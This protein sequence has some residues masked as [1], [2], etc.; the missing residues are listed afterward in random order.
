[1]QMKQMRRS[2]PNRI[3]RSILPMLLTILAMSVQAQDQT[4]PLLAAYQKEFV[5]LD[6]EI[7]LLR[8]RIEEVKSDGEIR[9]AKAGADL[10]ELEAELLAVTAKVDRRSEDL[11][12]VE[13]EGSSADDATDTLYAILT[14]AA[15]RLDNFGI[16]PF[17]PQQLSQ[18]IPEQDKM[19]MELEYGF[20][21]SFAL[22]ETLSSF[23]TVEDTF[24]LVDG[25]QVA[26]EIVHLG[27]IA[28]Y[29]IHD[30][31]SGTLAPAGGGRLKMV[32]TDSGDVARALAD[33]KTPA[34]LP[35]YLYESLDASAQTESEKSL[36]DTIEGGGM[37]GLVILGIGAV[38]LLLILLRILTLAVVSR[39]DSKALGR[40]AEQVSG[41]SLEEA[42]ETSGTLP[43]AMGRIVSTTIRALR[44]DPAKAEDAVAESVLN[45]QPKLE[46]YRSAISVF[47]AVAPLL[48]LLGTVTGMIATFDIITIH[49]T[50][51]PKLLSG[52]ISEALI[53]TEL[54]L[55]V[56]I[57]TLLI[58]NL[59]ASWSDRI[60]SSLEVS[61]LRLINI[62]GGF[63]RI[64]AAG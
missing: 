29:G 56:A 55:M 6:N 60:T 7:R 58:G 53:T 50:G 30:Q 46:R 21:S 37:I 40:V 1:M 57:P 32:R 8:E 49:G 36:R 33:G 18:E 41:G 31:A 61:A 59:L 44:L 48:G 13:D 45:E 12:I 14:Q 38:S 5:F 51:D 54:G 9:V 64:E 62:A 3:L 52:G 42:E 23:R 15:Q 27:R 35:L 10:Q 63:D 17:D 28:S 19:V 22:L 20:E 24:F 26:G 2:I 34:Q 43:G 47:A 16:Q 4:D 11:R 39:N 25:T